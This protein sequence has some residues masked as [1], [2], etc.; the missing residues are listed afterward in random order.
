MNKYGATAQTARK[1]ST[2]H[3]VFRLAALLTTAG[4][5]TIVAQRSTSPPVTSQML[6]D[7]SKDPTKWL[8][9]GGDYT[10]QRHSSLTQLTPQNV[11]RLAPRWLFQTQIPAPGRGFETTP[12]VVDGVMY[13]TGINNHAWA[14]DARTG[15]PIWHY[16]RKLPDIVRVCCG[17]VNH[18]LAIL[19]DKLFMGT[20]D[21]HL[22]ALDRQ[23]GNVVWDAIVEEPKNGY[24]VTL[25]PLV[26]RNKVVVG[27]SG[28]DFADRGFIDAYDAETGT[29]VWRFY[30][31][32]GASEKG[33][34]SWPNAEVMTRGGGA[35]WQ[36]GSYD[37]A[38]NLLFFGTGNPN[39]DYWGDDRT[40][41]NLYTCSLVVLDADTGI[42]KWHFQFTPHD[43]HDWDST[44]VPVLS[45]LMFGGQPHKVVMFANR[46]GFFYVFDRASGKLLLG[47][48]FT[49]TNWAHELDRDGRP[50]VLDNVG[51]REKCLPDPRGGTNF[52]PPSFD[53]V[54]NLFFV[55]ARETCVTWT[56]TKP[57]ATITLGQPVPSGGARHFE[58]GPEQYSALRAIDPATGDV[59]WEHRFRGY[60]SETFLDLSGGALSTDSGLVFTGDNDGYFYAFDSAAGKELWRFQTGASIWGTAAIT[61]MLDGVQWVVI[62]SGVTLTAFSLPGI[63]ANAQ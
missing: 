25:A 20:L 11:D 45:D 63:P 57:P 32:P 23:T 35:V 56:A 49:G 58:G 34:E 12:I 61:Y 33:S 59:R 7:S 14:L 24:S 22:V 52:M 55:T 54:R 46:N 51:T 8:M 1:D 41:D 31:V 60:P 27:V 9:F 6:L 10:S 19:G 47:K 39:P 38:Q 28:G 16:Q 4:C 62:P 50:V 15:R 17:M 40:G 13:I 37:P 42:L 3:S 26:V 43:V 30:T 48:R 36:T 29:R 2:M 53:P 18:G 21:A 5:L 44:Q